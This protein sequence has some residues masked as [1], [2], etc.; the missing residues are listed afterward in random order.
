MWGETWSGSIGNHTNMSGK[1]LSWKSRGN[2]CNLI[3][4]KKWVFLE[5][6]CCNSGLFP[7]CSHAILMV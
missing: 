7:A 5:K 4:L 1:L 2:N 6:C 3:Y